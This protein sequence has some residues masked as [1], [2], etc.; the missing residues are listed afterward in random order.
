MRLFV[1]IDVV[2]KGLRDSD[3]LV[4]NRTARALVFRS[5]GDDPPRSPGGPGVLQSFGFSAPGRADIA[6]LIP[7]AQAHHPQA[8]PLEPGDPRTIGPLLATADDPTKNVRTSVARALAVVARTAPGRTAREELRGA[9]AVENWRVRF[10]A[11]R[12]YA[13]LYD[14]P[15]EPLLPLLR[16][17]QESIR[18]A[19]A[20]TLAGRKRGS[21]GHFYDLFH[22]R[23]PG[24]RPQ[25]EPQLAVPLVQ[26]LSDE[27]ATVRAEAIWGLEPRDGDRYYDALV[28]GVLDDVDP[29]VRTRAAARLTGERAVLV[30]INALDDSSPWVQQVVIAKLGRLRAPAAVEPLSDRLR[31]K[32]RSTRRAA[33]H[34]LA[35]IGDPR[36]VEPLNALY[37]RST[38][39]EVR[40]AVARALATFERE[41]D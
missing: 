22:G 13:W 41:I 11:V 27:S 15:V 17:P 7:D 25:S 26:A 3:W 5:S 21:F 35:E 20:K 40:H 1:D 23:P 10:A 18:W 37:E 31:A 4:R 24:G 34:A 12:A 2:I 6:A 38:N 9:V 33:S 36:A 39:A 16:D 30:L 29:R 14:E 32:N 19:A 28:R 8:S